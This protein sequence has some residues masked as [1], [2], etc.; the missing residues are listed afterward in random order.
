MSWDRG[1]W[2]RGVPLPEDIA[3]AWARGGG[4]NCAGAEGVS[5]HAWAKA[6]LRA[7]RAAGRTK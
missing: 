2:E 3:L 1:L 4:H 7:L 6:N 5:I